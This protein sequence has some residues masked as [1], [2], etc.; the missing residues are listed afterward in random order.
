MTEPSL[1]DQ[2]RQAL[3]DLLR[4]ATRRAETEIAIEAGFRTRRES[5]EKHLVA[6][7]ERV[8]AAFDAERSAL[9][10][11]YRETRERLV[12]RFES[13]FGTLEKEFH[14][15]RQ[16]LNNQQRSESS[17]LDKHAQESA[18]S[19]TTVI[20]AEK[21][22]LDEEYDK[23]TRVVKESRERIPQV[24]QESVDLLEDWNQPTHVK[25]ENI[26]AVQGATPAEELSRIEKRMARA[27]DL[28]IDLRALTIPRL[29][30]GERMILYFFV[31]WI[32]VLLT[33]AGVLWL[34]MR[35]GQIEVYPS[36]LPRGW[37]IWAG[38]CT[39]ATALV[40]VAL[41]F[42]LSSL[43]RKRVARIYRPLRQAL[44]ECSAL[45]ERVEG[46]AND[47]HRR[48]GAENQARGIQESNRIQARFDRKR[49]ELKQRHEQAQREMKENYPPRLVQLKQQHEQVLAQ[50]EVKF[51][52]ML[53]E[54][55]ERNLEALQL[56]QHKHDRSV[57]ENQSRRER[58]WVAL[59]KDWQ[60][61]LARA[62]SRAQQIN[63]ESAGLFSAWSAIGTA[64]WSP[65]AKVPPGVRFGEFPVSLEQIPDGLPADERLQPPQPVGF[66]LP[67]LLPFPNRGALLLRAG[68]S[69]RPPALLALQMIMLRYLTALP[70]G[71]VRFTIIDPVGLG[72]NFASFMHLADY[73]DAFVTHRIWTEPSHIEQRLSDLTEHMENVI[74]KYLRNQF[75][76]IEE[77]NTHAGEVAEP[78]RILVV[79]DFPVNFSENA[80][81]R[82]ISIA[83]S[84]ASCGVYPL[85]CL[86]PKQSLPAGFHLKDLEQVCVNLIWK[87]GRFAWK[88]ND[89][90]R[91]PLTIDVPP[92]ADEYLRLIRAIG[93]QA[94][95]A[96]RVEVPFAHIAPPDDRYWTEDSRKGVRVALG[97]AGATKLQYMQLGQGT[98]QHVLIAGKT[99]S[100]KST[101]LHALI[102]NLALHYSPDEVEFYLIDFKKGVEFK[103][104]ATHALPHARVI[105]IE[106]ERE[107]GLSVLQ[108]LDVELKQRGEMFR[109]RGVQ[110]LNGYRNSEGATPLPRV[111][112]I[113]DEFQEYFIED[114]KI[115]QEVSLL[116]DRL[117][118]QGRAFGIHVLLGSQTLGGAYSLARS[119]LGQ[120][121][122]R[123]ALQC[124]EADANLI[125]SEDNTAARLLSRPGEAIYNDAN[126]RAE[127]NDFFQVVWLPD[128][129]KE[130][131]LDRI[132]AL[133]SERGQRPQRPLIVFEGNA[134]S[135][136]SK[137]VQLKDLLR[138]GSNGSTR[139]ARKPGSPFHA[140]LGEAMAIK[141]PT[142][143]TFRV[144]SGSNLLMIGQ[145]DEAARAMFAMALIALGVQGLPINDAGARF[146]VLDGTPADSPDAG[147]F[148]RL[149]DAMPNSIKASGFR[150]LPALINEV[151]QEVARRQQANDTESAPVFLMI[152]G[153]QRFRDLRKQDDDFSFSRGED[154]PPSPDKQFATIV[155]EGPAFGVFTIVWCDNLN[156]VNRALDRAGLREFEMRVLFQMSVNDS[157]TLIDTP[158]ASKLG[159][160]HAL[161]Y[162]EERG[163]AEKFRPYGL[164]SDAWLSS[165]KQQCKAETCA[166]TS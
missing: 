14:D 157:S 57:T 65:P 156:N 88:D 11:E 1:V 129:R 155:R 2:K 126:G 74:Q 31:L 15:F 70:P 135:D 10:N 124:S 138:V 108:R 45:C 89:F 58:E 30:K 147:Y 27:E 164:P 82:L 123:I 166:S 51:P 81:R 100:G 53:R 87:E 154:K 42:W 116:M 63:E 150:E 93:E 101:L 98:S 90:G 84:G 162:T 106:S 47:I 146:V 153:L 99:G 95:L 35:G 79:A 134:P 143:A 102:T 29:V 118:R 39:A 20:E 86:D 32:L 104:Y 3:Q 22:R 23:V 40:C 41:Q 49:E 130:W 26:A 105:A 110:D 94:K 4:L 59:I 132:R 77:Y 161:Y 38:G 115:A 13:E 141:D 122:V 68:E 12:A 128:E 140:W 55:K 25:A 109:A 24:L 145:Q 127:G 36:G 6:E 16:R 137:N 91:F 103:T 17:S 113:I 133:A 62:Q 92:S 34:M 19:A 131:Y 96:S 43:A 18:W 148:T 52:R 66:S 56:V 152:Y 33:L 7:R 158:A 69:G 76:T 48:L 83:T 73:N 107:F 151:A 8:Q 9:E 37:Y 60:E 46:A 139:A 159:Q 75:S 64:N 160:H 125:L 144:Q 67:A 71:K 21:N 111:L 119:T 80:A 50:L 142:A 117:V 44:E 28:L 114:D 85:I 149:V 112:L 120:M 136:I 97:R 61:G 54:N 163:Y 165:V 78:Y 121:A 72:E 5:I